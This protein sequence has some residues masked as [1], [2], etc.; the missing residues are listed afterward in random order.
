[1]EKTRVPESKASKLK[2]LKRI[3]LTKFSV[4]VPEIGDSKIRI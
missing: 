1:M 2:R 3:R 4:Q